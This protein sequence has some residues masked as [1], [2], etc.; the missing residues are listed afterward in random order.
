MI[1]LYVSGREFSGE[2]LT[3]WCLERGLSSPMVVIDIIDDGT[4]YN[5]SFVDQQMAL[6]FRL[7]FDAQLGVKKSFE[8]DLI[9]I[10]SAEIAHEIDELVIA[11][12]RKLAQ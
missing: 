11:D 6:E 9:E 12:L 4:W 7:T 10:L 1:H 8:E 5:A 2:E 3:Q